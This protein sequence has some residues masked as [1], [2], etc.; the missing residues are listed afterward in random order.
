MILSH[1]K[2]MRGVTTDEGMITDKEVTTGE[3]TI[4]DTVET[5][6]EVITGEA[7]RLDMLW[8]AGLRLIL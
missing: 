6:G 3:E 2:S 5:M 7:V 4:T 1:F 8:S